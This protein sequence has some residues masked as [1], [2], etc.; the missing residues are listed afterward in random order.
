M[1][2][3]PIKVVPGSSREAIE[4][5]GGTLK[6]RVT[7]P[8]ERGRANAAVERLVA[9]ALDLPKDA[10]RIVSGRASARKVVEI[11]GLSDAELRERLASRAGAGG[12]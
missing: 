9:K 3:L 11:S 6:V 2:K 12:R 10:A 1:I 7:A 5:L 8:A 4:W